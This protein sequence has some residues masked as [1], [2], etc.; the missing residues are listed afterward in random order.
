M[1]AVLVTHNH[2][3]H[4]DTSV[5]LRL[6]Q[7]IVALLG[8][9]VC[10]LGRLYPLDA[11]GR[12]LSRRRYRLPRR[13]IFREIGKRFGP[14]VVAILPIGAYAP[15]WFMQTQHANPQE[16]VQIARDCGAKQVLGVHWARLR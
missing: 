15:R 3:D 14:P 2:Y 13:C 16:A 6:W 1:D 10:A 9:F 7:T 4:L 12:H 5:L 8:N 11:R